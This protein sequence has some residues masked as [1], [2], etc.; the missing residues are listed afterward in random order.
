M[1]KNTTVCV[2][3]SNVSRHLDDDGEDHSVTLHSKIAWS[4]SIA[5]VILS[6]VAVV[7][8]ALVLAAIW[9]N[10]SLRTPSYILLAGLAFTD[11]CTGLITQPFYVAMELTNLIDPHPKTVAR[12]PAFLIITAMANGSASYITPITVSIIT[13]MSIERW[14]HMSRRS[15]LTVRRV[16]Y[17]V[18]ALFLLFI[19]LLVIRVTSILNTIYLPECDV[20]SMPEFDISSMSFLLFC[21]IVASIAYFKVFQIIR[22]HQQQIQASH[23]SQASAQPAIN[24]AKYKK[25]VFTVLC[26]LAIFYVSYIP[27]AIAF[28]LSVVYGSLWRD[29]FFDI[30]TVILFLSSSLNPLLYFW[31]MIDIRNEVKSLV[32]GIVP[33]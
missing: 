3:Y 8:N 25:S 13:V 2:S 11:F 19:P 18:A 27:I 15:F 9:R 29:P 5:V 14:L 33:L 12:R 1:S 4:V 20:S 7:G 17:L 28:G 24:F 31:R 21:L 26:I 22:N 6:P 10:P 16:C 23:S 30:P 32:K